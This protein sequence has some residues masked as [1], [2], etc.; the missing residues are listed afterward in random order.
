LVFEEG[1]GKKQR[2]RKRGK[3]NIWRD[4]KNFECMLF[5]M[6]LLVQILRL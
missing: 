1:K 3:K 2:N 5:S 6:E 4:K